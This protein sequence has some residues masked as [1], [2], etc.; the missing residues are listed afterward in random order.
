MK[1]NHEAFNTVFVRFSNDSPW[2]LSQEV[3]FFRIKQCC[4]FWLI[5]GSFPFKFLRTKMTPIK[6]KNKFTILKSTVWISVHQK[7]RTSTVDVP[8]WAHSF[9]S[10][11]LS[12]GTIWSGR[13]Q[14]VTFTDSPKRW[15]VKVSL[16]F[17]VFNSPLKSKHV[18][19]SRENCVENHQFLGDCR[20]NA[21]TT[22]MVFLSERKRKLLFAWVTDEMNGRYKRGTI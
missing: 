9:L 11:Y 6:V 15:G 8:F 10:F 16:I 4:Y 7:L 2:G 17:N 21:L 13:R 12:S 19:I 14:L 22:Q 18:A 5:V 3:L 1:Q 20:F